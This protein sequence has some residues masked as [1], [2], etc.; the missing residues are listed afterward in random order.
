M[1]RTLVSLAL[2]LLPIAPAAAQSEVV[3]TPVGTWTAALDG[4]LCRIERRFEAQGK[5]HLLILEQN[6]PGPGF[7]IAL[8]GVSL[9]GLKSTAPVRL[10]LDAG[11]QMLEWRA[12]VEANR[13]FGQV[14]ILTGFAPVARQEGAPRAFARIDAALL[15]AMDRITLAQEDIKVTFATG[16]L[17]DAAT[18]LNDCT[19][20]ILRTWGLDPEAQYRLQRLAFPQEPRPLARQMLKIFR[21][22]DL[23]SGPFE[24][25]VLVDA[26]G[27]ATGC[28]VLPGPG[29]DA[30]DD[31]ACK[32][33]LEARY[34]PALDTAG[35]PVASYW[36]T[37]VAY[38]VLDT[39]RLQL[40]MQPGQP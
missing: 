40:S 31:A 11:G 33:M 7:G 10:G 30:L 28:R 38:N 15:G 35:Q 19:A 29:Y 4:G 6:A 2:A 27:T 22:R 36:K 39:E 17:G 1:G 20:Q 12:R 3:A 14:A 26:T 13:Q 21:N 32:V 5:P 24:A 16:T 34:I 8:A 18:V 9:S 37:R 23:R 25:V